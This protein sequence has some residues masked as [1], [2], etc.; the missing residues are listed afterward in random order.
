MK[1]KNKYNCLIPFPSKLTS[2]NRA[3]CSIG[4]FIC[5][6]SFLLLPFHVCGSQNREKRRRRRRHW[7]RRRRHRGLCVFHED[8]TSW[9]PAADKPCVEFSFHSLWHPNPSFPKFLESRGLRCW[10]LYKAIF[11][12]RFSTVS[13]MTFFFPFYFLL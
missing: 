12:W 9:A 10:Y 6:V 13:P 3:K 2:E 4:V 8:F 5:R 11:R 1:R 7:Q